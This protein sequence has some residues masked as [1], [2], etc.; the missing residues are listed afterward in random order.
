L[1]NIEK[2]KKTY[3][4]DFKVWQAVTENELSSVPSEK[5][6][7]FLSHEKTIELIKQQY[8]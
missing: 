5:N 1:F 7:E 2:I 8:K 6:W 3:S 4:T